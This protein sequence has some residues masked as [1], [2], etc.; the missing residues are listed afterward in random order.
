[1]KNVLRNGD[2]HQH[3]AVMATP[4]PEEENWFIRYKV[5]HL[6]FWLLYHYAW[7]VVNYGRPLEV[8]GFI[9]STPKF[10]FYVIFQAAAVYFNL[11]VLI[12]RL[13]VKGKFVVYGLCFAATIIIAASLI[14]SG[15]F[16]TAYIKHTTMLE[17]FGKENFLHFF[18]TYSLPST[19]TSMFLAMSIKLTK[20]WIQ[21]RAREQLLEKEKMESELKFLRSQ[22][23]PHFLFNSINSIFVLIHKNPHLA[24]DAL[25]KFSGLLRYQ[26]YESNEVEISLA[27]ELR[28]LDNYIELE[29]LRQ[30]PNL[31]LN[32]DI[33]QTHDYDL[34]I[35]PLLL[36]PFIENAF[37]HVSVQ[38]DRE[39]WINLVLKFKNDNLEFV[40]SNSVSPQRKVSR[41]I[42]KDG[43]IGLK[44]VERRLNLI[45]PGEHTLRVSNDHEKFKVTLSL[46]LHRAEV[47]ATPMEVI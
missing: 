41:E 8:L 33:A 37:K 3:K 38:K 13:L 24:S 10:L 44:N 18:V 14:A 19:L 30:D 31:Q 26:L 5:Y 40:I 9:F 25:A 23:N 15:Y 32:I 2:N 35:A 46:T 39:N 1:M 43:G 42:I 36:I 6:L 17:L 22:L 29:K 7:T 27:Q 20:N 45:Y 4:A 12:P 21:S 16:L 34:A 28:Y 11:Y 47:H